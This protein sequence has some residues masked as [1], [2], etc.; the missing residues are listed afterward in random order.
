MARKRANGEGTI[1]K[2]ADGSWEARYCIDGKRHS[3]YGRTQAE[4]RKKLTEVS[5]AIDH[6]DYLEDS[7]L[8]L[9]QW[10]TMWQRDY[11][12]NVKLSTADTYEMQIRVHI[13]P[14]L[15]DVKLTALRM[16]MIQRLYNRKLEEGLSPKSI[17]NI[18]GCLHKALSIAVR[19]GYLSKNPADN[20][21]LPRVEMSEIHP[22]DAPELSKLLAY[23]KGHEHEALIVTAIFTGLRSGELLGLTW[24]CVD[25]QNGLI[26]VT[27][28]LA[29]P[30]RKGDHDL[31]ADVD[32]RDLIFVNELVHLR[33]ADPYQ[34]RRFPDGQRHFRARRCLLRYAAVKVR[35][36]PSRSLWIVQ[37]AESSL[38][39]PENL[40][41][42]IKPV[43]HHCN[44]LSRFKVINFRKFFLLSDCHRFVTV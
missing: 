7:G 40:I 35:R 14:V 19:I 11:M 28:Q 16:P 15:G 20:C 43:S 18:H 13:I 34:V 37:D 6:G 30:R 42:S 38:H 23:L 44:I 9:G 24:D 1:R 5:S 4:V 36:L 3:V 26:R 25:F 27:K 12:G 39:D 22:L 17:K 10:L 29:Q 32:G 2:R 33:F 31:L 41:F 21:I 8:T